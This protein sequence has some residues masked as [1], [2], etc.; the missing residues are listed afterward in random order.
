M[1]IMKNS[2]KATLIALGAIAGIAAIS[3][4]AVYEEDKNNR[5]SDLMDDAGRHAR[6]AKR[7][8][9][10]QW[11]DLSFTTNRPTTERLADSARD[12]YDQAINRGKDI[13]RHI[14]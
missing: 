4:I 13:A 10:R 8:L 14:K 2:T 11:D 3:A 1:T 7:Q 5:I 12:V 6:Q 9:R